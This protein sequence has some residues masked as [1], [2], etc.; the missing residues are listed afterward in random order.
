M[1]ALLVG[2]LALS[3]RQ[4]DLANHKFRNQTQFT[5][6]ITNDPKIRS[7]LG[8][9]N[10]VPIRLIAPNLD[11]LVPSTIIEVTGN[12]VQSRE[13]KVSALIFANEFR[14]IQKPNHWQKLLSKDRKSTRLNSSHT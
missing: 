9:S 3:I 13:A 12:A 8:K 2:G 4:T 5:I 1:V 7:V 10:G 6:E 11:R 14:I